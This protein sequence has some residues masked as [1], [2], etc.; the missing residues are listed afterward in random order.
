MS[1]R[2]RV[3]LL[4]LALALAVLALAALVFALPESGSLQRL[5]ATV[6]PT[7]FTPPP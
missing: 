7:L 1:R 3:Y 6:A 5:Q 2:T 4:I